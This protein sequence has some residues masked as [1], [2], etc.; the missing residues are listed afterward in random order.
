[1][2][3]KQMVP[4]LSALKAVAAGKVAPKVAAQSKAAKAVA[5]KAAKAD[6]KANVLPSSGLLPESWRGFDFL[7]AVALFVEGLPDRAREAFGCACKACKGNFNGFL[8]REEV[9]CSK[10][11]GR[12]PEAFV[13]CQCKNSRDRFVMFLR[14]CGERQKIA[15]GWL[16]SA[17]AEFAQSPAWLSEVSAAAQRSGFSLFRGRKDRGH[18]SFGLREFDAKPVGEALRDRAAAFHPVPLPKAAKADVAPDA[19][20]VKS[21]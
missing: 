18:Y 19:P 13:G 3:A 20:A 17:A 2:S 8:G 7:A 9:S 10:C 1:M 11:R 16:F 15:R 5:V 14:P 12:G 6:A 21:A 4:G